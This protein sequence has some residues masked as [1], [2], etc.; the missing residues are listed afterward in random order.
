VHGEARPGGQEQRK[1]DHGD[2]VGAGPLFDGA[3][4]VE[5]LQANVV[6]LVA[7]LL[8][9]RSYALVI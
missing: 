5:G 9:L 8:D 6:E 4:R 7:T 1:R 3:L 2:Q